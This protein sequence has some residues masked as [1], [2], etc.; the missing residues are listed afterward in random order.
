[1]QG[2]EA[3][4]Y[5]ERIAEVYDALYPA[6]DPAAIDLLAQLAGGGPALEL[7]IGTGRIALPLRE[8]GVDVRGV[9]ASPAM[10]A[11]LRE[12]PLGREIPITFGDFVEPLPSG[13]HSLVYVVFNTFFALLTQEAQ[14]SCF[15]N[16]SRVLAPGGVFLVQA[17]VPDLTRFVRDQNTETIKIEDGVVGIDVAMHDALNQRV[18]AQH[19]ILSASGIRMYPVEVRYAWPSELDLMAQLAGLRLRHRWANWREEPFTAESANHISIYEKPTELG[20][21]PPGGPD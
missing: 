5:G 4:T 13:P 10:V 12:K 21:N 7:G 20:P 16:V 1:M 17:F 6:H 3:A 2:Y 11:R 9:D 18:K 15:R 8:R 19:L 14:V